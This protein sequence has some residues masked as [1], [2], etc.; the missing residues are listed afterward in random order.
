MGTK[1][2]KVIV[3]FQLKII[4]NVLVSY[5]RFIS[6]PI[7][8]GST[9]ITMNVSHFQYGD[10]LYTSESDVYRRQILTHKDGRHAE[11]VN[12]LILISR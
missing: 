8:N 9:A 1:V 11:G 2:A 4:I 12:V 3:F 7:C 5:Y 10:R 6:I